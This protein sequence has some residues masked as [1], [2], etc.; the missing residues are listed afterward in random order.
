M[1]FFYCLG[2][3]LALSTAVSGSLANVIIAKVQ[4]DFIELHESRGDDSTPTHVVK[5]CPPSQT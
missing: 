1:I 5:F 2:A 3:I 4:N